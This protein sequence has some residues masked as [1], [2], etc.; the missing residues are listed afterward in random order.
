MRRA[1]VAV[2]AVLLLVSAGCGDRPR[3]R[4]Y[5]VAKFDGKPLAGGMIIFLTSDNMT[6]VADIQPDGKYAVEGLARGPV[7]VS[8][9]VAPPRPAPRPQPGA[10]GPP[11]GVA[12]DDDKARRRGAEDPTP[13][14][15]GGPGASWLPPKYA[16]PTQSGLSFELTE[17][18]FEYNIDLKK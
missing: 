11:A 8:V 10:A 14:P 15:A 12:A 13:P 17:P 2:V 16:D 18:N 3:S 9:Q 6:A 1:C 4:V 5:G 7:K